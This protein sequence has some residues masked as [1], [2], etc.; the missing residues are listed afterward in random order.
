MGPLDFF[1]H[2]TNLLAVGLLF[3]LV[4]TAGTKLIWR[5]ALAAVAWRRL[6]RASGGAAAGVTLA[7]LVVFGR[8]GRMATYA[9]MVLAVAAALGWT[10]LRRRA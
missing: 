7:G 8:D 10:G 1:W 9:L 5:R 6:L 2:L 3:A 4:A